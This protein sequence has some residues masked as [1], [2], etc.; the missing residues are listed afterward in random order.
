MKKVKAISLFS[1]GLDSI[2]AT[3]LVMD[4]GVAVE[5]VQFVTPFFNYSVLDDV[6]AHK[7]R[8]RDLYGIDVLV[9]DIS[10]GYLQLLH[11]PAHGFGKNFNPCIDCKIMMFSRAKEMLA[12]R[13]ARFLI[14]GEVLGQR[15]MSQ[16]RDTMNVI[17]RDS[18]TRSLLLRPLCARL[19]VETE[20][21]RQGWVDRSRLLRMS[22]RGRSAQ[23]AL[24][25]EY[26]IT[27]FPAPAGGCILADPI[28]SRRIGDLYSRQSRLKSADISVEDISVLLVGRQ[29][30]LPSGGWL[31]IGR[32]EKDNDKLAKL[33]QSEDAVL[34]MEKWPGP[35]ALLKKASV[36]YQDRNSLDRDLQ[37]AAALVVRY[38][39]K[40][41]DD[42]LDREVT[43]TL[44][45]DRWGVSSPPFVGD[46]FR[47]WIMQ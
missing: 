7:K 20:A 22:G 21:E 8:M 35:T 24:A 10:E 15:P 40:M 5:A 43:C 38:G 23:I 46:S 27:E 37:L 11:H 34:L 2:L 3:R 30:V 9:E 14:S 44:G 13:G 36:N 42:S 18:G 26:G 19:M 31:I 29:L 45:D 6:A 25:K 39:K 41:A 28:L 17:E 47:K 12:E 4:Q 32:D 1:G 33:A 16:R